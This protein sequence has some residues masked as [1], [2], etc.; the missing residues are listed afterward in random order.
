MEA[1]DRPVLE[2]EITPEMLE[3][4]A[5][6][7]MCYDLGFDEFPFISWEEV[8]ADIIEKVFSIPPKQI[9]IV[10]N[11]AGAHHLKSMKGLQPYI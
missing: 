2:I 11:K 10:R 4:G 1:K 6:E 5:S 9:N 7:L 3:A 8:V